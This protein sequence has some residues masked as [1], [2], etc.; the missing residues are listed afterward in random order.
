MKKAVAII[1]ARGGSKRIPR[2]N[3]KPFAGKPI[4]S[5]SIEAALGS[6]IFEEVMVST[7]DEEIADVARGFGAV[8]P[9]M[10]SLRASDDFATTADVLKEVLESYRQVGREFDYACC[11]YPTAPFVSAAKLAKAFQRLIEAGVDSVI[12]VTKFSFPIWRSFKMDDGKVSY[13]WPEFAPRR[14]QDLPAA[15]HD[16]GQ[17]YFFNTAVF[18]ATGKLVTENTLGLE[19][20]ETEVQDIDTEEDWTIAEIKYGFL[21]QK[22]DY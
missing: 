9:F 19:V 4:I 1:T 15:F 21:S 7:D 18:E 14:S 13:N 3:I 10:R 8:V 6:S 20:P 17:F 22:A 16:C 12:P 11:I 5:Y 2:K